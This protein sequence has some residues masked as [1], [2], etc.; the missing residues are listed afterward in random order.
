MAFL[1]FNWWQSS[2]YVSLG[3]SCV[4]IRAG[5]ELVN[6]G[7]VQKTQ[8]HAINPVWPPFGFLWTHLLTTPP[9]PSLTSSL[10]AACPSQKKKKTLVQSQVESHIS[11]RDS[12]VSVG[13]GLQGSSEVAGQIRPTVVTLL[14][15]R[16]ANKVRAQEWAPTLSQSWVQVSGW[17]TKCQNCTRICSGT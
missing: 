2:G 11:Q 17:P 3:G 8:C 4:L 10:V 12:G 16:R 7:N 5:L 1:Y 6:L 13:F 14:H 9:S 15:S